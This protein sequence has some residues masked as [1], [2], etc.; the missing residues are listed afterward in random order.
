[1]GANYGA[2]QVDPQN[3]P[4]KN[5]IKKDQRFFI[6]DYESTGVDTARDLPIEVG[7]IITDADFNC[8][9]TFERLIQ[10]DDESMAKVDDPF[11]ANAV[12]KIHPDEIKQDGFGSEYV[13]DELV[14]LAEQHTTSVK[15]ILLSDNIQFEWLFTEVLLKTTP[16]KK[17]TDYFHYCGWDSSLFLELAGVGDPQNPPHRALA[18]AGIL[19]AAILKSI[20]GLK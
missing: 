10:W 9:G 18:D 5:M 20:G 17:V 12:H 6:I 11:F 16:S 3:Q 1:V 15:P 4:D 8:I 7:I 2:A 14:D 19:H 13:G